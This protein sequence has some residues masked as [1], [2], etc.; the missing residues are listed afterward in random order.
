MR[1]LSVLRSSN[2]GTNSGMATGTT[3]SL[4]EPARAGSVRPVGLYL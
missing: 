2:R 4:I 3:D 1:W